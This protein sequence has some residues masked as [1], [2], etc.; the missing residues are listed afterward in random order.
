MQ[1]HF[2]IISVCSNKGCFLPSS[3]E[4]GHLYKGKFMPCFQ[5]E[6]KGL[7]KL[8]VSA[9]SQLPSAQN[10]PFAKA[11]YLGLVYSYP[12]NFL[13]GNQSSFAN[14]KISNLRTSS[15]ECLNLKKKKKEFQCQIS[16]RNARLNKVNLIFFQQ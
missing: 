3:G 5:A 9:S 2:S 13:R 6:A 12:P 14:V 8:P 16:L 1:T 10:I 7:R 4:R 15:L 11:A